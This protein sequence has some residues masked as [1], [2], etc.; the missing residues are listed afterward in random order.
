MKRTLKLNAN[1]PKRRR[2]PR[3]AI[4]VAGVGVAGLMLAS[5]PADA[6]FP[7]NN[8]SIAFVRAGNIY[9]ANS[10]GGSIK[11]ITKNRGFSDPQWSPD[12]KRLAYAKRSGAIYVRTMATGKVT[13]VGHADPGTGGPS[14][15]GDGKRVGWV[16]TIPQPTDSGCEEQGIYVA[17]PNASSAPT[18]IYNISALRDYCAYAPSVVKIG[19]WSPDSTSILLTSCV[20]HQGLGCRIH[21]IDL[22][23][24]QVKQLLN[25]YCDEGDTC[26][27][28]TVG[29]A[30]YGPKGIRVLFSMAGGYPDQVIPPFYSTRLRV[31]AID[32]PTL[33]NF[34]RVSTADGFDPTSSP[35]GKNV[36]FTHNAGSTTNIMKSGPDSTSKPTVLIKNAG[37][38]D[39]QARQ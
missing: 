35:N 24:G 2:C 34:H 25:I 28:P 11:Q 37:Q 8:G 22:A 38:A 1:E 13:L 3:T 10:S 21:R 36:L 20:Y 12:G 30:T 32:W 9:T 27:D 15:S 19:S 39:W 7:G 29:A 26:T 16:A 17:P 14:W 6:T 4:A 23:T 31:Y 5:P 33:A 18:L